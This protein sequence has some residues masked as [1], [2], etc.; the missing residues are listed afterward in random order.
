MS[1]GMGM[2]MGM[3]PWVYSMDKGDVV[4]SGCG[5]WVGTWSCHALGHWDVGLGMQMQDTDADVLAL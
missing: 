4:V 1:H 3:G 5:H 2:G